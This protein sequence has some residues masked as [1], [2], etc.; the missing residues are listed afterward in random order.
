[1]FE[2]IQ[3]GKKYIKS[4]WAVKELDF[5]ID[6][7]EVVSLVGPNGSGK[8]T[9]IN[10]ILGAI[11]ATTGKVSYNGICNNTLEFKKMISYVPDELLLTESLT[12][13]EY[14]DFVAVM[15]GLDESTKR[16]ELVK[17]FDMENFLDR[18]IS[19]Y[20]HGMKKKLQLIS[21]FM[22][23]AKLI[24]LDEPFRGLDVEA[25]IIATKLMKKYVQRGNSILLS[26]HDLNTAEQLSDRI[27][28]ISKG[29]KMTDGSAADLKKEYKC[30][31][32]EEV[33]MEVSIN[34]NRRNEIEEIIGNL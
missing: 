9:T 34:R 31:T 15:Y 27:I 30:Q 22:L 28:I 14:L 4:T 5:C 23:K 24:I 20:S 11:K 6:Q 3:L 13:R 25:V 10:C 21:A 12:G 16:G 26:T 1:M 32:I 18:T 17:L 8:T 19:E 33:F 2:V 29:R 7:K